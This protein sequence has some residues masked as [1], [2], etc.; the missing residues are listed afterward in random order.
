[1]AMTLKEACE[2]YRVAASDKQSVQEEAGRHLKVFWEKLGAGTVLGPDLPAKLEKFLASVDGMTM[3]KG[4]PYKKSWKDNTSKYPKRAVEWFEKQG[5][6][7]GATAPSQ[8]KGKPAKGVPEATKPAM[9][10][11]LPKAQLLGRK[12]PKVTPSPATPTATS[13]QVVSA[14]RSDLT[15]EQV[16]LLK[17]AVARINA[18]ADNTAGAIFE[19][20]KHLLQNH[21]HDDSREVSSHSP[22]KG[23]SLRRLAREE[24]LKVSYS[25]LSRALKLAAHEK[26]FDSVATSQ[27]LSPSHRLLLLHVEDDDTRKA[28]IEQIITEDPDKPKEPK[29]MPFRKLREMLVRDGHIPPSGMGGLNDEERR[30]VSIH[31]SSA[32]FPLNHLMERTQQEILDSLPL[33]MDE[34]A[35]ATVKLARSKMNK[36][37]QFLDGLIVA[38]DKRLK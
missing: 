33:E 2:K 37:R 11:K 3:S 25:T 17:S 12:T 8:T 24:E 14:R 1:M 29:V 38:L 18:L 10:A 13:R 21:F 6:L 16:N 5:W 31:L 9:P 26:W 7:A 32:V 22:T 4:E 23:V 35:R 19:I 34:D 20:G 28:Y 15:A 27:H 30:L 36:A